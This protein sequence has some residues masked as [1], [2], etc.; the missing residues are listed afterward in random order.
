MQKDPW[1]RLLFVN[2]VFTPRIL[3]LVQ[4]RKPRGLTG[5]LQ[6]KTMLYLFQK[7]SRFEAAVSKAMSPQR[8][9][10]C[11]AIT[12]PDRLP[13][14]SGSRLRDRPPSTRGAGKAGLRQ[15]GGLK[16]MARSFAGYQRDCHLCTVPGM[17]S[18]K[19][20]SWNHDSAFPAGAR[21]CPRSISVRFLFIM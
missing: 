15:A 6:S 11:G 16:S 4:K 19:P 17:D 20:R 5:A 3:S 18:G 13:A 14:I 9:K 12:A 10:D 2:D 7:A 8:R 1:P 21:Q